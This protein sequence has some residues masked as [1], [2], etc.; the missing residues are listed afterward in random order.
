MIQLLSERDA[1]K[2]VDF[3]NQKN[4][5]DSKV[6]RDMIGL[7]INSPVITRSLLFHTDLV[8]IADLDQN[9]NIQKLFCVTPPRDVS[10]KRS[11]VIC[12]MTVDKEFI[13]TSIDMLQALLEGEPYTKIK[14]ST[15]TPSNIL[16]DFGFE[17]ELNIETTYYKQYTYSYFL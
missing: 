13:S 2:I 10:A 6:L 11:I 5:D 16:N 7:T 12:Y 17:E 4:T 1:E 9:S 15:R 8:C 14:I 3:V